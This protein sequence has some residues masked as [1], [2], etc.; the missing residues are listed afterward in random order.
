MFTLNLVSKWEFKF[1]DPPVVV[2]ESGFG[3]YV[4]MGVGVL[5][6]V[7]TTTWTYP[8]SERFPDKRER[9]ERLV[10]VPQILALYFN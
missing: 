7:V 6:S 10:V 5:V 8:R 2:V 1:T 3:W 9:L 4:V